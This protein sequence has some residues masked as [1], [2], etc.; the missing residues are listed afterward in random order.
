LPRVGTPEVERAAQ[1]RD[2]DS[3]LVLQLEIPLP[4]RSAQKLVAFCRSV[5]PIELEPTM[6]D[7]DL[8]G[9]ILTVACVDNKQRAGAINF[10][11]HVDEACSQ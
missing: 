8:A 9:L 7:E 2:S 6:R 11:F 1:C 3:V 5:G 10:L 4:Q